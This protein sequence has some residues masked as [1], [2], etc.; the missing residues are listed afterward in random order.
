M[1]I[2]F[3]LSNNGVLCPIQDSFNY[4]EEV[5]SGGGETRVPGEN[6]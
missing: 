4:I 2:R 1:D 5:S 6:N 3:E